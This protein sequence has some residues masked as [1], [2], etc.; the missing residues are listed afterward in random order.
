[1]DVRGAAGVCDGRRA[2][3]TYEV[4]LVFAMVG[5]GR[6]LVHQRALQFAQRARGVLEQRVQLH[7]VVRFLVQRRALHLG[8]ARQHLDLLRALHLHE[9]GGH[10]YG[11]LG[12]AQLRQCGRHHV[13]VGTRRVVP[14]NERRVSEGG[15]PK[16]KIEEDN[17]RF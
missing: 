12:V 2:G 13:H 5:H 4:Q 6:R 10:H 14:A 16:E 3:W 11:P 17:E 1:V 9:L 8:D 15:R 7:R